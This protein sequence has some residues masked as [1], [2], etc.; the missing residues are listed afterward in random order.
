MVNNVHAR[1]AEIVEVVATPDT[2]GGRWSPHVG[3]ET[4]ALLQQLPESSRE[5]VRD[6]ALAVLSQCVSPT[7]P[8]GAL[9]GLVVGYVQSGKTMSFTTVSAL[10][11]DNGYRLIIVITGTSVPLFRQSTDR[12]KA[13]LRLQD[14]GRP[15]KHF[16]NPS[17]RGGT[18]RRLESAL[19]RWHDRSVPDVEKQ[20]VLVTVMKNVRH[21]DN[22]IGLLASLD[23]RGVPAIIIDDEAD[24]ASLNNLVREGEESATYR[25][26]L[27]LREHLP[28]HT[29][30]QYTATPQALLLINLIDVLSP[31]FGA[32]LTPGAAYTG[33]VTFFEEN[34]GL[35]QRGRSVPVVF[36]ALRHAS[37]YQELPGY[38]RRAVLVRCIPADHVPT[39]NNVLAEPPDSL[40]EALRVFFLGVA[41][42]IILGPPPHNRS[43]M[44]HPSQRTTQHA[45]YAHWVGQ[46]M[47]RWQGTLA[48]AEADTD[49]REL[50]AEFREAY[51]DLAATTEVLPPFDA[52]LGVL[53]RTI[54]EVIP[55]AVN[56]RQ[57]RTPQVEW[58]QDYAYILIGGQ[59]LDRG[60]TVEGLTVTY[61]PRGQGVGNADTIQQR[62]RWFGYKADYLG[63]CRVYLADS[64]FR[65]YRGYV[66][67]EEDVRR[68][69]RRH[70]GEG[71][72]LRE[73]R[74]T[75]LLDYPLR[76]TRDSVLDLDYVRGNFVNKWYEPRA[77][78]HSSEAIPQNRTVVERFRAGLH[79]VPDPGDPRRLDSQR[80]L[81]VTDVPL[82]EAY[83]ELLAQLRVTSPSDSLRF[84][85]LLLQ[86]RTYLEEHPGATCTLYVMRPDMDRV[87][88][89]S[90][91]GSGEIPEGGLFQGAYPDTRGEVYRGD[92]QLRAR[93]GLTIQIH[94]LDQVRWERE[95]VAVD[96]PIIAVWVPRELAA[97]WIAQDQGDVE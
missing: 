47:A 56:A 88:F 6:E 80:H 90:V 42:G 27:A 49:R 11:Q 18:R 25:R 63:Y 29:F 28:Q 9:T 30:L 8:G 48:Q 4:L 1:D 76:P 35:V 33:G 79:F 89:R 67:H 91:D 71:R 73:W 24:Q 37:Y 60:Y 84:T 12:L 22:L 81:I 83:G 45:D 53:P 34:L 13:D 93:R 68:Q 96:V 2:G 14:R 50:V 16:P 70:L 65:A 94:R 44:I 10:A 57:G 74:R 21:L 17:D 38:L 58:D 41:A 40:L 52:L 85:G 5:T 86:I 87:S 92:R 61:M 72:S 97:G 69:L 59:A 31:G 43:M 23:L 77:P 3:G 46:A 82:R 54:R 95:V 75:F 66:T 26:L 39:R 32:V 7:E 15:W 36:A 55:L 20:T 19:Q 62:A 64:T 51:D 78:H